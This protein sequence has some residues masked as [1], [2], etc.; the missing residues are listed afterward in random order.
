LQNADT[1]TRPPFMW[2][3]APRLTTGGWWTV[4]CS[5]LGAAF[6]PLEWG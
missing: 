4:K 1:L 3:V 2:R 6:R 5:C